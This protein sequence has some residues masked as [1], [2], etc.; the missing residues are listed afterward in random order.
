MTTALF[1][2]DK[3]SG[4]FVILNFDAVTGLSPEDDVDVTDHNVEDGAPVTDNARSAPA[5]LTIEGVVSMVP[6]AVIDDDVSVADVSLSVPTRQAGD[7]LTFTL[8]IPAVPVQ[9]SETGLINA[10][11]GALSNAIF[12]APK[13]TVN[14]PST[15]KTEKIT[16]RALQQDSRRNRVRA[17]YSQLLKVKDDH[18][19]IDVVSLHRDW[20]GMMVKRVAAPRTSADGTSL[21]FQIDLKQI[22]IASSQTVAAPKPAEPR[23]QPVSNKG[24]QGPKPDPSAEEHESLLKSGQSRWFG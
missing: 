15:N 10:G 20:R 22:R 11:I 13:A 9:F 5:T 12:G 16:A 8:D 19:L 6:N 4:D 1:W 7:K 3:D 24:K 14:G 2:T 23:A 17:F 18:T 21:K